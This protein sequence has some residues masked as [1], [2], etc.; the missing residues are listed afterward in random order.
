V[1]HYLNQWGVSQNKLAK[2]VGVRYFW[3]HRSLE[4]MRGR[5]PI[6]KGNNKL[7]CYL[8]FNWFVLT[9]NWNLPVLQLCRAGWAVSIRNCQ[10]IANFKKESLIG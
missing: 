7:F 5:D 9:M 1:R 4:R 10:D 6:H 2:A 8:F 3:S